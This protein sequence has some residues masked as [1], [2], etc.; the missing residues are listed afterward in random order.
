MLKKRRNSTGRYRKPTQQ[1]RR[2]I[3]ASFKQFMGLGEW[4]TREA[5]SDS[6]ELYS[7]LNM[8]A[9]GDRG[10]NRKAIIRVNGRPTAIVG[11]FDR[12]TGD[13]VRA[14]GFARMVCMRGQWVITEEVPPE[15]DKRRI[16]KERV[17]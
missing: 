6:V 14:M 4:W 10:E 17:I 8:T 9:H 5:T 11:Y 13:L 15:M 16:R 2:E 3:E 12:E 1:R 7:A